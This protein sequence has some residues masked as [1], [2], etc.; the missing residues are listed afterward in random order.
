MSGARPSRQGLRTGG[1]ELPMEVD[2]IATGAR[3]GRVVLARTAFYARGSVRPTAVSS[4]GRRGGV[5]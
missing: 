5:G 2:A 1:R 3:D 4:P